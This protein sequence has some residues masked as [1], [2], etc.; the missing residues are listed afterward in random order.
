[1]V[2]GEAIERPGAVSSVNSAESGG[3][4]QRTFLISCS[5]SVN[6]NGP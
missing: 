1:M 2:P 4:D 6:V 3:N 5:L